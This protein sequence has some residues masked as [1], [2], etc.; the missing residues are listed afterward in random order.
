MPPLPP[1]LL[2]PTTSGCEILFYP[3]PAAL[4]LLLY[5]SRSR[6][7][8]PHILSAYSEL[9]LSFVETSFSSY[10]LFSLNLFHHT[11]TSHPLSSNFSSPSAIHVYIMYLIVFCII[12]VIRGIR[13]IYSLFKIPYQ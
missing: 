8:P 13:L 4:L 12:V 6:V 10:I 2:P 11:P 9:C 7:S 3:S 1:P 5:P